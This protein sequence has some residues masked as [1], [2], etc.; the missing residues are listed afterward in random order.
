MKRDLKTARIGEGWYHTAQHKVAWRREWCDTPGEQQ[1]LEDVRG[2]G[3]CARC[4]MHHV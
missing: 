2:S 3:D 1:Q 4:N